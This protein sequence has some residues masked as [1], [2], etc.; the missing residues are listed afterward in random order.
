VVV[1]NTTAHKNGKTKG[2]NTIHIAVIK[3]SRSRAESTF[4]AVR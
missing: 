4:K 3:A 1:T 2:F